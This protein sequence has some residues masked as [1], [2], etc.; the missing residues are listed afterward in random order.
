MPRFFAY[1]IISII[2]MDTNISPVGS[3]IVGGGESDNPLPPSNVSSKA[4]PLYKSYRYPNMSFH[5]ILTALIIRSLC[6]MLAVP[7]LILHFLKRVHGWAVWTVVL[8][9]CQCSWMQSAF[10]GGGRRESTRESASEFKTWHVPQDPPP[11]FIA[12][13]LFQM[14]LPLYSSI[15]DNTEQ[16]ETLAKQ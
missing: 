13:I 3:P 15:N 11:D 6:R 2:A 5:R 7:T 1:L 8:L 9:I 16:C 10:V 14:Y 12:S 4:D